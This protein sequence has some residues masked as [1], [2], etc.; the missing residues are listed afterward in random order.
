MFDFTVGQISG[1]IAASVFILQLVI[2]N[3]IPLVIAGSL[4]DEHNSVTWG[5]AQREIARSL[6][7]TLTRADSVATQGVDSKVKALSWTRLLVLT[8]ISIAAIV[9]P[10]GLYDLVAP[11]NTFTLATFLYAEDPGAFGSA[12]LARDDLSFTRW[13][14]FYEVCP[15]MHGTVYANT[16]SNDSSVLWHYEYDTSLPASIG[17]IYQSGLATRSR[18]L[19]SFF[20]L[21]WRRYSYYQGTEKDINYGKTFPVGNFRP[22]AQIGLDDNIELIEGLIVDTNH[23]GV[24]LRNHSVPVDLV[25]G[26]V[27][28]E[29]ILFIEPETVCVPTNLSI[30]FR[31][32]GVGTFLQNMSLVD[33]GGFHNINQSFLDDLFSR[34]AWQ[35]PF[36]QD[37]PKL[38]ERAWRAAWVMSYELMLYLNVTRPGPPSF[39]YLESH[40][41]KPFFLEPSNTN[42]PSATGFAAC[43]QF[44]QIYFLQGSLPGAS[45]PGYYPNPWNVT[46]MDMD[47]ANTWCV[48]SNESA[49]S[50]INT[51]GVVCGYVLGVAKPADK[52]ETNS[53]LLQAGTK[54]TQ[55]ISV[56]TSTTKVSIKTVSFSYNV[57]RS[58]SNTERPLLKDL[59]V[60]SIAP[61]HHTSPSHLP[62]WGVESSNMSMDVAQPLWG[63]VDPLTTTPATDPMIISDHLS[64]DN[65]PSTLFTLTHY[66]SPHL[67]LPAYLF[68]SQYFASW[69]PL[70]QNLPG[71]Q[72]ALTSLQTT[73]NTG[74]YGGFASSIGIT[75]YSGNGNGAMLK[76]W[77]ELT[78]GPEAQQ[79]NA[80]VINWIWTDL[81]ANAV[82]GTRGW[83]S[84]GSPTFTKRKR[85]SSG[86]SSVNAA[87]E[88][89]Q[90]AKV[91]VYAYTRQV[92]YRWVYAIPAVF[93]LCLSGTLMGVAA[94]TGI[95][96]KKTG[97]P[98]R[99]AELL[100]LLSVGRLLDVVVNDERKKGTATEK[101]CERG[102]EDRA[103]DDETIWKMSRTAWIE[104]SG[105]R[106]LRLPVT[107]Q[108][109]GNGGENGGELRSQ[110]HHGGLKENMESRSRMS[111]AGF[112]VKNTAVETTSLIQN[113]EPRSST[114]T[115]DRQK[116][117]ADSDQM[118][119]R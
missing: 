52:H 6:W 36:G 12:T 97:T 102:H 40:E 118:P 117:E 99:I 94:L 104:R 109:D 14:G 86:S 96:G 114:D 48:G 65:A 89:D 85:E 70:P 93:A 82:A 101:S 31:L 74:P 9:T 115:P 95:T 53:A 108:F 66:R 26:G 87:A 91:P 37:D 119:P 79:G 38:E 111:G 103:H 44:W 7:P 51:I 58:A 55:D 92:R 42:S 57:T 25:S 62:T 30:E 17:E 34:D 63:I 88:E 113:A 56:C 24:G 18:T 33:H 84:G 4:K 19:S 73:Y 16:T 83:V 23:G 76:R 60:T 32:P 47:K 27:W 13:C 41:G 80:K 21:E 100:R 28:T 15:G 77:R 10:L 61:K 49:L 78:Q 5:V 105:S 69:L 29:D 68:G 39:P 46:T 2:P 3:T 106:V 90:P 54:W 110:E 22:V 1:I 35:M 72:A 116:T 43:T 59:Q 45:K 81:M 67:Y 71:S 50:N 8:I 75:D 98:A 107:S 112:L 11:S 20:D 64:P